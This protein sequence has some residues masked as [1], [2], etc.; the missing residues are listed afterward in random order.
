[1]CWLLA[2]W[3]PGKEEP[4]DFWLSNLPADT[5][6]ERLVCLAKLRWRIEQDYRELKDALGLDHFE[7]R[8]YPGGDG[9]RL[10]LLITGERAAETAEAPVDRAQEGLPRL[11]PGPRP[12]RSARPPAEPTCRAVSHESWRHDGRPTRLPP[13]NCTRRRR[14]RRPAQA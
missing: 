8:S 4:T 3:P 2:E 5:P 12:P 14:S 11:N 1:M 10:G 7:G 9:P 13:G 6:I